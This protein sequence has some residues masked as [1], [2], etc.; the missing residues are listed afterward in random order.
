[1]KIYDAGLHHAIAPVQKHLKTGT[2]SL[3]LT[4]LT[5]ESSLS[6]FN[7]SLLPQAFNSFLRTL[8]QRNV[9][10]PQA[11]H[12]L[13]RH[14]RDRHERPVLRAT[15]ETNFQVTS[16]IYLARKQADTSYASWERN[17]DVDFSNFSFVPS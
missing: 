14:Q 15:A 16:A 5:R 13:L 17:R 2:N 9:I 11:S 7:E 3:Q 4:F 6:E 12:L 10:E 1:M 8:V